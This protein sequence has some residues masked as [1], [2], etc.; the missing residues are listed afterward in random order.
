[1]PGD[2]NAVYRVFCSLADTAEM[3][4]GRRRLASSLFKT[5][6]LSVDDGALVT[7]VQSSAQF[8]K[9]PNGVASLPKSVFTDLGLELR[10]DPPDHPEFRQEHRIAGP[11]SKAQANRMRTASRVVIQHPE[12]HVVDPDPPQN[13]V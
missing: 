2:P 4:D 1:M 12:F 7:P 3:P 13:N 11:V 10:A 9:Q 5:A 8:P 6:E